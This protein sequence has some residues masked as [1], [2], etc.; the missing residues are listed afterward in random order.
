MIVWAVL[1]ARVLGTAVL[2]CVPGMAGGQALMRNPVSLLPV[3]AA[4]IVHGA[5][6]ATCNHARRAFLHRHQ[7]WRMV[8]PYLAGTAVELLPCAAARRSP[9]QHGGG[10]V[11]GGHQPGHAGREKRRQFI[12][13]R[14]QI[15]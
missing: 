3:A 1:L 7:Q 2:S 9:R 13:H 14:C 8:P 10:S 5:V 4:M 15:G 11:L 6:Q 12:H